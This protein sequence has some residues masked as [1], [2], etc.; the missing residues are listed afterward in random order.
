LREEIEHLSQRL[1]AIGYSG[2]LDSDI[3]RLEAE[4]KRLSKESIEL[5]E[6]VRTL[7]RDRKKLSTELDEITALG[8]EGECPTCKR[9]LGEQY[10]VLEKSLKDEIES[11]ESESCEL[12]EKI[13]KIN[14]E[15]EKALSELSRLKQV[16]KES[17]GII[18]VLDGK[19]KERQELYQKAE[20]TIGEENRLN[21]EIAGI[22]FSDSALRELEK[23]I[24]SRDDIFYECREI[25]IRLKDEQP[26]LSRKTDIEK[27]ISEIFR[28]MKDEKEKL[29]ELEFNPEDYR[30]FEAAFAEAEAL[31]QRYLE[32]KPKIEQIPSMKT[33]IRKLED[34]KDLNSKKIAE[35]ELSLNSMDISE[36]KVKSA[37]SLVE[38]CREKI[39]GKK[40]DTAGFESN[41]R[42]LNQNIKR[43]E[44]ELA[45]IEE[46]KKRY[47]G[48][49]ERMVVL[50]KTRGLMKEYIIY[51]LNVIRARIEGEVGRVL[52][53]IT[54]GRYQNVLIDEN[55]DLLV[56]DLGENYPARRFSG[57]EQDDIAIALR[58]ALSRYLAEMHRMSGGTFMIFDEIFGSQDEERRSNLVSALRTQESHF[59]QIFLISHISEIQGEFSTSLLVKMKD[60]WNSEV[61]EVS[62]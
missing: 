21:E 16:K 12:K 53:E 51:L 25:E 29:S 24:K 5:S 32:L 39:S 54:G 14:A 34:E 10:A 56:N 9:R 27:R 50:E 19:K 41:I 59:P 37:I 55:F 17:L 61:I 30:S 28:Q 49:Q 13:Q 15:N 22:S 58:I 52:S 2:E 1:E 43:L 11:I 31:H 35:M 4:E 38:E 18:S 26:F 36:D 6:S 33:E 62:E 23:A 47:S 20:E 42:H 3:E 48:L 46:R 60:D 40:I 45:D 7:D 57:G 8:E 44:E